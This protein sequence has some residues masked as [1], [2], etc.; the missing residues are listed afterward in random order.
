[1]S[2][3][4]GSPGPGSTEEVLPLTV[5]RNR[6]PEAEVPQADVPGRAQLVPGPGLG[7]SVFC[8]SAL[9]QGH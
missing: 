8:F 6:V 7:V 5:G 4:C 3:L 9:S 1:M 2:A